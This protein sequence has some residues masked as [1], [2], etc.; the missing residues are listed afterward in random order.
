MAL[1]RLPS[2]IARLFTSRIG[3]ETLGSMGLKLTSVGLVFLSTVILARMLGPADYGVYSY[4]YA[5]ISLLSVP[6]EFGL[7]TLVIRETASGMVR[8]DYAAVQG[9]W[10]WSVRMT[11]IISFSL[12]CLT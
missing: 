7:P 11:A 1:D 8:Q 6:S 12:V 5:L 10:R 4:V 2:L 9:V 3:R